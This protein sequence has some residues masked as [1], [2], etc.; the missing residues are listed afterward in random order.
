[1]H[2]YIN[3]LIHHLIKAGYN[4]RDGTEH[5]NINLI[6][7]R[8]ND[9][10][11]SKLQ[12]TESSFIYILKALYLLDTPKME[13][14]FKLVRIKNKLESKDNNILINYMFM[15]RVQCELQLSIQELK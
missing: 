5:Y 15:G 6:I 8:V 2:K 13:K 7:F 3:I 12:C 4:I 9:L 10:M 11:R 1:M 14:Y